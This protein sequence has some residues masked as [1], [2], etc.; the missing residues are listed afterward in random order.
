MK[1]TVHKMKIFS[2]DSSALSASVAI[3]SDG[4]LIGENFTNVNLTHSQTLLPMAE[5]L[6]KNT[7]TDIN[8][9]DVFS[10]SA[11]PGSFTGVRIGV[12]AIKGLADGLNKPC[13]AVSTLE[14]IAYPYFDTD[15]TVCSVMDARCSQVY[16]A[17]FQNGK[18]IT[19]D[20]AMLISDLSRQIKKYEKVI[21]VGDGAD[22][23]Y[24][25][26]KSSLNNIYIANVQFKFQRASSVAFLTE[27]YLKEGAGI[28]SSEELLPVY[29]RLPQAERELK[30]KKE[31]KK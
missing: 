6:L 7:H 3:L 13:F 11:G 2:V 22:I 17:A 27:K 29:L 31:T 15:Y 16:T 12:S 25:S 10:V 23:C 9:I 1:L 14:S 18:R 19:E 20:S 24:N 8:D 30:N 21:F 5:G 26:L 4:A 28:V